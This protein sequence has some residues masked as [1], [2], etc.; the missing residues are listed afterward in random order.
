M[1]SGGLDED[2][3]GL[4]DGFSFW[5]RVCGSVGPWVDSSLET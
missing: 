1:P 5:D 2:M 3:E 4:H